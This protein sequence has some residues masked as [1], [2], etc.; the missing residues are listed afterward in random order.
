HKRASLAAER[1]DLARGN[2]LRQSVEGFAARVAAVIDQL[3][4]GQRQK[5]LRLLIE[6]VQVTGWHIQI[7]LRIPL[8]DPPDGSHPHRPRPQPS[9]A[10]SDD[11]TPLVSTKDRLRSLHDQCESGIS[12]RSGYGAAS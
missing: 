3:D 4:P 7:R 9:P 10:H 8:D 2:R 11:T 12:P 5:L 1:A 6:D